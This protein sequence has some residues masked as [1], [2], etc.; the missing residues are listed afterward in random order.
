LFETCG[1]SEEKCLV[2]DLSER[3]KFQV[4]SGR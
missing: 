1:K 4:R 3:P 2:V